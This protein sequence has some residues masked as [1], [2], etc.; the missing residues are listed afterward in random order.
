MFSIL[1]QTARWNQNRSGVQALATQSMPL[2]VTL[3]LSV[4]FFDLLDM[5]FLYKI[6]AQMMTSLLGLG[7]LCVL[8]VHAISAGFALST[9]SIL[10]QRRFKLEQGKPNSLPCHLLLCVILI[11]TVTALFLAWSVPWLMSMFQVSESQAFWLNALTD[12]VFW[13]MPLI[14][15]TFS[16]AVLVAYLGQAQKVAIALFMTSLVKTIFLPVLLFYSFDAVSAYMHAVLCGFGLMLLSLLLL[17]RNLGLLASRFSKREWLHDRN[18]LHRIYG[19]AA[20]LNFNVPIVLGFLLF[21]LSIDV[22]HQ[23]Q[24]W[25]LIERGLMLF[26][27]LVIC[28]HPWIKQ[29]AA[30]VFSQNK[31][32]LKSALKK[33]FLCCFCVQLLAHPVFYSALHIAERWGMNSNFSHTDLLW[34]GHGLICAMFVYSLF[35]I[36]QALICYL[37][38]PTVAIIIHLLGMISISLPAMGSAIL[39]SPQVGVYVSQSL[40]AVCVLLLTLWSLYY[41][42]SII[43]KA[44]LTNIDIDDDPKLVLCGMNILRLGSGFLVLAW[45]LEEEQASIERLQDRS[46]AS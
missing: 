44:K 21:L 2:G 19:Y 25:L 30:A 32:R 27:G 16:L 3:L 34:I 36:A 45:L 29:A 40:V 15:L 12:K 9:L 23:Y 38:K 24:E 13:L 43:F 5:F 31:L 39:F 22:N 11:S 28:C 17:S 46:K 20:L 8:F 37:G 35:Y 18:Y 14:S 6:N 33:S 1:K 4:A 26:Y 7:G 10:G 42:V 41:F